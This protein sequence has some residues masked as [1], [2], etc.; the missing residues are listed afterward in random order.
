M[1]KSSASGI[2]RITAAITGLMM[3][4]MVLFSA[5]YIA[6]ESDHECC[7]ED[8]PICAC[9]HQCENTLHGIG[10]GTAVRSAA[11]TPVILVLLAAA[12]AIPAVS[13]DTLISGKVRL[14]N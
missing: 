3:L 6:A 11:A 9:I 13:Q 10:D 7:G 8:C 4:V 2:F 1:H 14:N 5:F 12:F